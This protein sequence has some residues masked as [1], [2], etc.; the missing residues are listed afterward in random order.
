MTFRSIELPLK[1]R[2]RRYKL[3][4]EEMERRRLDCLVIWRSCS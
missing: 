1:E 3:V 2:D 4:R